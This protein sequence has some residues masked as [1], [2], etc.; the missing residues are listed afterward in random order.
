[1]WARID[2]S[3][4]PTAIDVTDSDVTFEYYLSG[5]SYRGDNYCYFKLRDLTPNDPA[6]PGQTVSNTASS[7]LSGTL[8]ASGDWFSSSAGDGAT[9]PMI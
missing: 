6:A 3:S 8:L 1:M 7:V 5:T 4:L 2:I 9:K